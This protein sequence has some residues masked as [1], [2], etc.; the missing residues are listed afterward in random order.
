[1]DKKYWQILL[2]EWRKQGNDGLTIPFILG[3]KQ[4]C[5]NETG[6]LNVENLILDIAANSEFEVY[7]SYCMTI[8]QIVLGIRDESKHRNAGQFLTSTANTNSNL[9][10]SKFL[11]DFDKDVISVSKELSNRYQYLIDKGSFSFNNREWGDFTSSEIAF[12]RSCF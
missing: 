5:G 2:T 1:M 12:I 8:A 9:F 4:Y 10:V 7:L 11:E 6:D 3:S